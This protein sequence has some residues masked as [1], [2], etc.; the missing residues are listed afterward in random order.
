VPT[1]VDIQMG[2]ISAI[3]TTTWRGRRA[4]QDPS[5]DAQ[6]LT[7]DGLTRMNLKTARAYRIRL[8]F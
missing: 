3:P 5:Y 7:L 4:A 8:A 1:I 2:E 6:S